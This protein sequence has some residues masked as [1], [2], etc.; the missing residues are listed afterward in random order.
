VPTSG[1]NKAINNKILIS[2]KIQ[3]VLKS[4]FEGKSKK[5]V[6]VIN[7]TDTKIICL[8]AK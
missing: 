8:L 4:K 6:I 2:I 7:P 3:S 1:M 5:I